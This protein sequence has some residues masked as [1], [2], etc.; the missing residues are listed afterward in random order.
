MIV[1]ELD[2]SAF[3]S[4]IL[5]TP[6]ESG[7]RT[8]SPGL[9]LSQIYYDMELTAIGPKGTATKEELDWY[10]SGG[11]IWERAFS[12]AFRESVE[13]GEL[14]RPDE[15]ELDGIIGSP[16]AIRLEGWRI[17]DYKAR[18]MSS[19]KLDQLEKHFYTV[20]VQL[21]GYC[22]MAGATEAELWCWFVNG[23]YR[24]PRP[25]VRGVL[26]EFTQQ[27]IDESWRHIIAH[28]KRRGWLG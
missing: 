9:H 23:D 12:L 2:S 14:V 28:A 4:C 24:P 7:D 10:A 11:W 21:R 6:P 25:V 1:T 20:I 22:K 19:R 13:L 3:P 15:F 26:L 27:E 18:W 8:R 5:G 16:D 17:V